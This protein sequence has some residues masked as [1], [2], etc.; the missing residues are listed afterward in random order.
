MEQVIGGH[1]T[2]RSMCGERRKRRTSGGLGDEEGT[3]VTWEIADF[4]EKP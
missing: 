4:H 2:A 1:Y 3:T